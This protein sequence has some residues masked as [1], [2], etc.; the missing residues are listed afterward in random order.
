MQ[1]MGLQSMGLQRVGHNLATEQPQQSAS[2]LFWS[3]F[4]YFLTWGSRN[5]LPGKQPAPKAL[6]Q[7]LLWDEPKL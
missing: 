1:S 4:P 2:I 6:S 5:H 3:H 7:G